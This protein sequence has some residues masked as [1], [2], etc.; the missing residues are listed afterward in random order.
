MWLMTKHG[1]Y[2]IVEKKPGEFHIRS[3]ECRDLENLK[4]RVPMPG[5]QVLDTP[6]GDYAARIIADR[7]T[8]SAVLCFL[9]DSLDYPNFKAEIDHTPD[10]C[11]KPYHEVWGVMARA[12]GS[13]GRPGQRTRKRQ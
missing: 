1:F 3:R 2:S 6:D 8:V 7:G 10:Q 13:Y 12:L 11:H 4:E 5:C 9:A